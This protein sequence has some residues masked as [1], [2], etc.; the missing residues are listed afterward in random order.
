MKLTLGN[1]ILAV[2]DPRVDVSTVDPGSAE[3]YGY[4][5]LDETTY[6]LCATT[7]ASNASD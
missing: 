5:I 7:W 2:V 6:E 1:T 4:E 3:P